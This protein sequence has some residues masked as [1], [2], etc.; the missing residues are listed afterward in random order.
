VVIDPGPLA[1]GYLTT[2]LAATLAAPIKHASLDAPQDTWG[3]P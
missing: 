3:A 1:N 2:R